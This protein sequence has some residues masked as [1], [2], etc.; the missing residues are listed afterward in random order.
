MAPAIKC[1]GEVHALQAAKREWLHG[2][3]GHASV[4]RLVAVLIYGSW[5]VRIKRLLDEAYRDGVWVP[6]WAS[7]VNDALA[8]NDG[9]LP[10]NT[11]CWGLT[12]KADV[13]EAAVRACIGEGGLGAPPDLPA[14]LFLGL[15]PEPDEADYMR[16]KGRIEHVH[17]N[18]RALEAL[19]TR[20]PSDG[21]AYSY[22]RA[23]FVSSIGDALSRMVDDHGNVLPPPPKTSKTTDNNAKRRKLN[24]PAIRLFI[25]G[26]RSQVGKTSI[27]LGLLGALLRSGKY[28][29]DD[30]AYIKPAT[31]CEQ[32]QL[33]EHYCK[34]KGIEACVPVG[35][36][37][38]YK[39]FTRAFLKGE[40]G[41]T[42]EHLLQKASDAVDKLAREKKVVVVDGVG[43]PAVGS[44]TGTDNASVASACGRPVPLAGNTIRTPTPVLLVGKSGV[45]DAVDSFNINAT[46]FAHKGVPVIG[47]V[48]NKLNLDGFYSLENCKEA[49]DMYFN[50]NQPERMPFGFIPELPS[51]K[52]AREHAATASEEEQLQHSLEL[53]DAFV[54]EFSRR[55]DVDRILQAAK[56]ATANYIA[57]ESSTLSAAMP[58]PKRPAETMEGAP[59]VV[60]KAKHPRLGNGEWQKG[61]ATNANGYSLSREQI[62]AAA[63]AAGAAGG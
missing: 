50:A 17:F 57:E 1:C 24:E 23:Q 52:N 58:R 20:P 33:V 56:N 49:L 22:L 12:V 59:T 27:C 25:A 9:S 51:L 30:L 15:P 37:V 3:D 29:P 42:S 8:S 40:T 39:G 43:Y 7:E 41:E 44:I 47:A 11:R 38:Y 2:G 60:N 21:A 46:Y 55:V 28:A 34:S 32:T 13:D 31:Q 63:S 45:G 62:E 48:F 61:D 53:A 5:N 26:D 14:L 36:V 19:L 35:P 6:R 16:Q 4:P 10:P 54:Q 18:G